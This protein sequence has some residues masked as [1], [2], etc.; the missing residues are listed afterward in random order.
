MS[1][2]IAMLQTKNLQLNDDAYLGG[3]LQISESQTHN[4][5]EDLGLFI[6]DLRQKYAN[7]LVK[8]KIPTNQDENWRFTDLS[9]LTKHDFHP[10]PSTPVTGDILPSF[11]LSEALNSRLVFVNGYYNEKLSD[12]SG[13]SDD[14]YVGNL[15]NLDENKKGKIKEYLGKN[16]KENEVFS[17]LNTVGLTDAFVVWVNKNAEIKTPIHLL[18]LTIAEKLPTLVQPRLLIVAEPNSSANIIEYY[19][20]L[21][22]AC[23]DTVRTQPYFTNVVSEIHLLE[24]AKLNHTRIQRETGA[25]FH[26]ATTAT[27]LHRHSSYTINEVSLG[28]KLYRH[29]L[30]IIQKGEQ[31]EINLNGLTMLQGKQIA[32]THSHV[33]LNY[34]HG[35]V[36]QLH[37]YI[38][39]DAGRGIFNGRVDVPK[40]AQMT[41]AHQLNRNLLLSSQARINTKPELQITADN[42]KCTHGATVSQLEADQIFYLR[43]R[44]LN[45]SDARYLLLDAFAK[46]ML[47][48]IPYQSLKQRLT[49]CVSCRTF[50]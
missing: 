4:L 8:C 10:A 6:N 15:S 47:D 9:D 50:D 1:N 35:S 23:S 26:I 31:T 25:G 44:G 41:S 43:S 39:D 3:L 30:D 32:D 40:N 2:S 16:Q 37:K 46:E 20:A 49:Q 45:E 33:M 21:T 24:N 29:N 34:P 42:V 38:L 27:A 19:G 17:A 28:G 7:Q 22:V 48:K 36:N 11:I 14:I 12:I 5:T 13:L 18:H